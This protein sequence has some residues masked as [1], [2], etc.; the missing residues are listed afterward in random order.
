MARRLAASDFRGTIHVSGCAKGCAR[1]ATADL[2]LVGEGGRFGMV[3]HGTARDPVE[4]TIG[5]DEV[6]VLHG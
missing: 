2:T 6:A 4:R 1:S 5:I 3:R